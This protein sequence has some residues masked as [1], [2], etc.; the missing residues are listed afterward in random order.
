MAD[1]LATLASMVKVNKQEDV[2]SIQ[3]SIYEAPAHC[4]NIKEEEKDDHSW[5]HD[6][7]RYVKNREYLEQATEKDKRTLQRLANDYVLDRKILYK[8]RKDQVVLRCVDDVKA[9]KI[10]E[11]FHEGI[12]GTHANGFT[13]ARQIMRFRYYWSTMEGD[14]ISYAKRCHKCQTYKDKIHVPHSPLHVMTSPWPFSMWGMDV[15]GPIFP[16]SFNGH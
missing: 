8:R 13:M 6:I 10:L 7:L 2:K 3:M 14:C 9:K 4:N 16:K 1:A 12:C 15:I 5:Y 11:E